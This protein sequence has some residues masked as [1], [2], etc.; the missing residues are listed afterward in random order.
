ME[1]TFSFLLNMQKKERKK[2]QMAENAQYSRSLAIL[3]TSRVSR[4]K[5]SFL[6]STYFR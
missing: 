5:K 4:K 3:M 6:L 2:F 1:T